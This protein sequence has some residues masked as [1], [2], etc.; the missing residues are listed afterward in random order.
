MTSDGY[1]RLI[2]AAIVAALLAAFVASRFQVSADITTFLPTSD[3]RSLGE[4]SRAVARGPLSR[5]MVLVLTAK[6]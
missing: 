2:V 4:F 1:R 3:D 6:D 5:T